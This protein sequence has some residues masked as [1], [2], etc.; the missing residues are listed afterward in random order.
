MLKILAK[1]LECPSANFDA[2][3]CSVDLV[4]LHYTGMAES[5]TALRRL[6]DAAPVAGR[7]PGPWQAPDIDP[8]T[9]LGR[10]SAHYVVGEDG[11]VFR[12]VAEDKRAWHAGVS[13]WEGREDVNSRS[14]GIEIVNGGHDYGLPDFPDVQIEAVTALLADILKRNALDASRVLAHSDIAP[15]RKQDPGEKFPWKR[16]AEAGVAIWPEYVAMQAEANP[17]AA[18]VQR[19]LKSIGY[20]VEETG[21]LDETTVLALKAFQR[22]FR[23]ERIDGQADEETQM[24]LAALAR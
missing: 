4:I 11:A 9:P 6:T 8:E 18:L 5:D 1:I 10:A 19:Q 13:S 17:D 16:L 12:L 3:G 15:A 2:R 20:G 21:A 23:P 14:I 7:Y 24:L 22:R